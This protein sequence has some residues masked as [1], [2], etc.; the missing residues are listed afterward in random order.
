MSASAAGDDFGVLIEAVR[1]GSPEALASLYRRH[2]PALM[3]VE[4]AVNSL[5][6]PLRVVIMLREVEGYSH[7]EVADLLGRGTR[8]RLAR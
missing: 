4:I 6:D 2:A 5:P 1:I 8:A 3:S 7:R